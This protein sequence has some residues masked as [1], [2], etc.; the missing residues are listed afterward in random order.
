[1]CRAD[2]DEVVDGEHE[3]CHCGACEDTDN[4]YV[5]VLH[6]YSTGTDGGQEQETY[7][8][9]CRMQNIFIP[10]MCDGLINCI[11]MHDCIRI[12]IGFV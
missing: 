8:S 5:Y 12:S 9:C 3:G 1:M 7:T 10:F 6:A 4:T 11:L 2:D